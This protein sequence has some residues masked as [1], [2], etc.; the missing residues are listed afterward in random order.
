MCNLYVI[1]LKV[2]LFKPITSQLLRN[3][4]GQCLVLNEVFFEQI[5][6]CEI[7]N[8]LKGAL[9]GSTACFAFLTYLTLKGAC[10]RIVVEHIFR[11]DIRILL[12][13][14]PRDIIQRDKFSI[15]DSGF[16]HYFRH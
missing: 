8:I 4:D 9:E 10:L 1:A 6:T 13:T 7:L 3:S 11:S 16:W 2:H 14:M 12:L 15:E 5:N